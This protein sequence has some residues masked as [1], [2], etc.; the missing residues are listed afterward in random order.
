MLEICC[1]AGLAQAISDYSEIVTKVDHVVKFSVIGVLL[2]SIA[3]ILSAVHARSYAVNR[4]DRTPENRVSTT[5]FLRAVTFI[6]VCAW[7]SVNCLS[8]MAVDAVANREQSN[9]ID[10]SRLG[11]LV[12]LTAEDIQGNAVLTMFMHFLVHYLTHKLDKV[13]A[14]IPRIVDLHAASSKPKDE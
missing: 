8:D 14:E 6:S 2:P 10:A 7:I 13:E 5:T 4:T 1:N 12:R 9:T 3:K 11:S